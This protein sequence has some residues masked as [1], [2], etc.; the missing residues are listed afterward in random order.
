MSGAIAGFAANNN[1]FEASCAATF[2]TGL[3]SDFVQKEKGYY[4]TSTDVL[5]KLSE[6]I[7]WAEE[8]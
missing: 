4:F 5:E 8:F 1:L 2:V 7:R 6:A 3:A